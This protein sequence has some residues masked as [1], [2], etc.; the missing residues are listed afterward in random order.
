MGVSVAV[1]RQS[2]KL[3]WLGSNPRPPANVRKLIFIKKYDIIYIQDKDK[4]HTA[5]HLSLTD[6]QL[7]NYSP[8]MNVYRS[9]NESC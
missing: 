4:A 8:K 3:L 2:L 7:Q 9:K 5:I 6:Y 1:A